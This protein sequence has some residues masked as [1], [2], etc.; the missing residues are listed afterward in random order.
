MSM[1]GT[2]IAASVAGLFSAAA[3]PAHAADSKQGEQVMCSGVNACKGHGACAGARN[4]CAGTNGCK[5]QGLAR[6]TPK[7]C[8]DKG[9]KVHDPKQAKQGK[10]AKGKAA[11]EAEK[12]Q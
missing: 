3:P 11:P 12:K 5:G 1:K 9:G 10:K 6:T 4:A 8:A 2:L 7:E